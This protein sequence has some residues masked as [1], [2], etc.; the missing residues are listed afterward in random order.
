MD[1]LPPQQRPDAPSPKSRN[2]PG[3]TNM[4]SFV[5]PTLEFAALVLLLWFCQHWALEGVGDPSP[6][7]R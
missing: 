4:K 3:A 5:R 2:T 7:L 1:R 6:I